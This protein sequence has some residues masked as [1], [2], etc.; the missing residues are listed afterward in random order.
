[1]NFWT[2][3]LNILISL[4]GEI[5]I[6]YYPDT[7][8]KIDSFPEEKFREL[9]QILKNTYW[10]KG[11][12]QMATPTVRG[13]EKMREKMREQMREKIQW[14]EAKLIKYGNKKLVWVVVG[15]WWLV[16]GGWLLIWRR[17]CRLFDGLCSDKLAGNVV[18]M[19]NRLFKD[20]DADYLGFPGFDGFGDGDGVFW[21]NGRWV[22]HVND[23]NVFVAKINQ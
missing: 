22:K 12:I 10:L 9:T 4:L 7:I 18:Q 16:G 11:N 21:R 17:W 14:K 13:S 3:G 23:F 20:A 6:K 5:V 8:A 15:G 2:N 19:R 1:M